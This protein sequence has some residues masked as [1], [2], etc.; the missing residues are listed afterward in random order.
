M[1][2]ASLRPVKTSSKILTFNVLTE[3]DPD[4]HHLCSG[5]PEDFS[6]LNDHALSPRNDF[7]NRIG[8]VVH[9][10]GE[11]FE[12]KGLNLG[13]HESFSLEGLSVCAICRD[14][15]FADSKTR[16]SP[17]STI[18]SICCYVLSQRPERLSIIG[19]HPFIGN[20]D[21]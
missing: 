5:S 9:I 1:T 14:R 4:F 6:S 12:I 17:K 8:M 13:I 18:S 16:K 11:T 3:W 7:V 15:W 19:P 20:Y 21:N 2:K 10:F